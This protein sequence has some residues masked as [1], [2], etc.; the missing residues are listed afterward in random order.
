MSRFRTERR[1]AASLQKGETIMRENALFVVS[2]VWVDNDGEDGW[3]EVFP[4]GVVEVVRFDF[5]EGEEVTVLK[6]SP[7]LE[8]ALAEF[9]GMAAE[10]GVV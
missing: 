6:L 8:A 1:P 2:T 3:F 4:E 5:G 10:R 7:M 9:R